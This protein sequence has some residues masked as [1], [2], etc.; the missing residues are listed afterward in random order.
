MSLDARRKPRIKVNEVNRIY[1]LP[2]ASAKQ[3]LSSAP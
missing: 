2:R 3:R 1:W